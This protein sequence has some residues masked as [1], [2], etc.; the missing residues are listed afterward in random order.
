VMDGYVSVTP[1]HL[2]MTNYSALEVLRKEWKNTK[3]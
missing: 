3:D 1:V 2:D